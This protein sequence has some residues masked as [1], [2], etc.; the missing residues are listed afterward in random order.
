MVRCLW[1]EHLIFYIKRQGEDF[2]GDQQYKDFDVNIWSI[3]IIR[4]ICLKQGAIKMSCW[5]ISVVKSLEG[6]HWIKY[7]LNIPCT[8]QVWDIAWLNDKNVSE[9]PIFSLIPA[10]L[11]LCMCGFFCVCVHTCVHMC[12]CVSQSLLQESGV[13]CY[14]YADEWKC[15]FFSY[16]HDSGPFQ[17]PQSVH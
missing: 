13:H 4:S 5:R 2:Q 8:S 10:K 1:R 7:F 9:I 11:V 17:L 3:S 12:V 14:V 15:I 6:M 16:V